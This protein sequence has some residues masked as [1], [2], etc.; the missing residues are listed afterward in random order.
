[1]LQKIIFCFILT[2]AIIAKAE[3]TIS[4]SNV[5]ISAAGANAA[6]TRATAVEKGQIKAFFELVKLHFPNSLDK[7]NIIS[8]EKIL[9]SVESFEL[10]DEK[11]SATN[12][13]AKMTVRFNKSTIE[14]LLQVS[15]ADY[16]ENS[17]TEEAIAR[18]PQETDEAPAMDSLIVPIYEKD[19]QIYWLDDENPWHAFWQEKLKSSHDNKFVLPIGDL[20]DLSLLN[21]DSLSKNLIDLSPL[22]ERYNINNIALLKL[23]I[24]ENNKAELSLDYINRFYRAWQHHD[25]A[26]INNG[27]LNNII[28]QYYNE[29]I[30]FKFNNNQSFADSLQTRDPKTIAVDFPIR[31]LSDWA[32]LE[33][34]LARFKFISIEIK[35]VSLENYSF[36]LTYT[37]DFEKLKLI[38]YENNFSLKEQG[39]NHYLMERSQ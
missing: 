16:V 39:K 19:G 36:N 29:I 6:A 15:D 22:L 18:A 38:L 5:K 24:S 17:F 25:F 1:M 4:I 14:N 32:D 37:I 13:F 7:A 26:A 33:Q 27:D 10:S 28:A 3:D 20:E 35:E 8:S 21:K 30:R 34:T 12:Y 11:R 2:F 9:N 23:K 31:K